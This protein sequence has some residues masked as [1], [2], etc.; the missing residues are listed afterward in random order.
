MFLGMGMF[1]VVG[2]SI[3]MEMDMF[4]WLISHSLSNAPDGIRKSEGDKEPRGDI[5]PD[6]FKEL[7]TT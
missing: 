2:F 1:V 6:R 5:T 3:A 4:V 7:K